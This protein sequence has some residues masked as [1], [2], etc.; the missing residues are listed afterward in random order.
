[1]MPSILLLG[2]AAWGQTVDGSVA[3]ATKLA[4]ETTYQLARLKE[5]DDT[6]WFFVVLGL[7]LVALIGFVWAVYRRDAVELSRGIARLCCGLRIGAMVMLVVFFLHPEGRTERTIVRNSRVLLL[8]DVSQSMGL[9]DSDATA[10]PASPSRMDQVVSALRESDFLDDLRREHDVVLLRF[11]R[12]SQQIASLPKLDEADTAKL[13]ADVATDMIVTVEKHNID[14]QKQFV[15]QGTE[16]RI[17]D[18]IRTAL[19]DQQGGPVS[20]M[21]VITDGAQNAGLEPDAALTVA[22]DAHIPIFTIGMGSNRQPKNVRL[23]D[24]LAPPRV[25][26]NDR[27]TVTGLIQANGLDNRTV[28]V[29][30][31]SRRA[32][33]SEDSGTLIDSRRIVLGSDTE[34]IRVKFELTAAEPG[35]TTYELRVIDLADDR[36]S[37]DNRLE[38]DVEIVARKN[39]V[40]LLAS[41]PSREYRFLRNQLRRDKDVLVDVLLQSAQGLVSQDADEIL[42]EFPHSKD[43]LFEYDCI[44]A[45]DPDWSALDLEKIDLLEQWVAQQAGG[46]VLVA[47]PIHTGKWRRGPGLNKILALYPVEFQRRFTTL[48]DA[49]F[50]ESVAWPVVFSREGLE[51][52]F[53]WLDE[54]AE[55]SMA[56]WNSF[57][58]VFGYYAVKGAKP[59]ATVYGRFGDPQSGLDGQGAVYLAAQFYGAG[60]VFY[61]GSGEMWRLRA[62]DEAYF[63]QLYTKLIRHVSQGRLL[64]GSSQGVLLVERD[65][66]LLGDTVVLRAQ[67]SN[68][69]H[70]PLEVPSVALRVT[71]PDGTLFTIQLEADSAREGMYLGQFTAL[72]E[73]TF[74]VELVA[75]DV[76]E[77]PLTSRIQVKVPD[78]EREHAE[79][80]D[81]LLS[82][83]ATSTGGVYYV[84]LKAALGM[85][86]Q[87]A[88]PLTGHLVSR[89]EIT[90][91]VGAADQEFDRT[92]M[93]TMLWGICGLLCCEWLIRRLSKLA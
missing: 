87:T 40:L 85:T 23:S 76:T 86:T 36:N 3:A 90:T 50:G 26:P 89:E 14:W 10:V 88:Q 35:R 7:V 71:R 37:A 44:V 92:L 93:Q 70:E 42:S 59:G 9:H 84:G 60:R 67:L 30:L 47:G 51:A 32:G 6:R 53:L 72:Q 61:L 58:G 77:E 5:F 78:L 4:G 29:E 28:T 64:R 45:F 13:H 17:G 20:A 11:D 48:N 57:P 39:R 1:M 55:E 49:Q 66:Y 43:K 8:V 19:E 65:R 74:R 63:E 21:I 15:P 16:T 54:S 73:G 2:D 81:S 41:G 25:F 56:S 34:M 83:I 91:L 46:L 12:E 62:Y 22:R 52:E 31:I 68:A 38:V 82:K 27:F 24:F 79:R 75:P 33:A 69:L 80:N 18:A